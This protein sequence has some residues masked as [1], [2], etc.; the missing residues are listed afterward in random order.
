M[1]VM[2]MRRASGVRSEGVPGRYAALAGMALLAGTMLWTN[3]AAAQAD[4][5]L[6]NRLIRLENDIQTLNRQ[7][8]RGG[9]VP[10]GGSGTSGGGIP[11]SLAADFEVKIGRAH[12]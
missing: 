7:V 8:F 5:N 6:Q 11:S 2:S 12:V 9:P 3:P 4:V 10:Q 1:A